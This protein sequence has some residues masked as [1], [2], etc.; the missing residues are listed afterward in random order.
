MARVFRAMR[1]LGGGQ[2]APRVV[3]DMHIGARSIVRGRRYR[4]GVPIRA[5]APFDRMVQKRKTS[6]V[7][8]LAPVRRSYFLFFSKKPC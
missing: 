6:G 8:G 5:T 4:K 7:R 2:D 1:M 3:S